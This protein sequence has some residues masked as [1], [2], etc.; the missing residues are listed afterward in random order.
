MGH[1]VVTYGAHPSFDVQPVTIIPHVD[2]VLASLPEGFVPDVMVFHDHS[3][4]VLIAGLDETTI[5]T[6]FYSVDTHHHVDLHVYYGHVFDMIATAQSDYM[7]QFR[8]QGLSISWLPLWASCHME[9]SDDKQHGAVFV[10]TLNP[11]LNPDRVAFFEA[12]EKRC[13]ILCKAG[14]F[15]EIFPYSEVVINQTVRGDL[16]FRVFET[17][18]SGAML[19]TERSG[20]GLSELFTDGAHLRTYAKGDVE[21]AARMIE[22]SLGDIETTRRIA[23]AGRE[24]IL[25][26]HT[27]RHRAEALLPHLAELRKRPSPLRHFGCALNF[28][29]IAR[30]CETIEPLAT[31]NALACAMRSIEFGLQSGERI[32]EHLSYYFI[33]ACL[34]YDVLFKSGSGST[35]LM[36]MSEAFP[37]DILLCMARLRVLLNQG[38]RKEAC[39]YATRFTEVSEEVLF[40]K[41][42]RVVT[43][44]LEDKA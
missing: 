17:M 42:E 29:V 44:L 21:D 39:E 8:E 43:G 26:R 37:D 25:N 38:R 13:P 27:A 5:P 20:N 34:L 31:S 22:L 41:A 1:N 4:P 7:S 2:T 40:E 10:G 36:R 6:F 12:L 14:T 16:N 23:K 3:A 24:E 9:P 15:S 30:R 18:M 35:V 32:N 28:S 19:L 11:K 33:R